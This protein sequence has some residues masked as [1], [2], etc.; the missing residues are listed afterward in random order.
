MTA[1]LSWFCAIVL[2]GASMPQS[3]VGATNEFFYR[4]DTHF[5][6]GNQ[7]YY[8]MGA[9]CFYLGYFAQ[10]TTIATNGMTWRDMSD[11]VMTRCEDLGLGVIRVWAFNEA[12]VQEFSAVHADWRMQTNP[13]VYR[14]QALVGLDYVMEAARQ[15]DLAVVLTLVNNWSAYGGMIWYVT[16]SPTASGAHDEFYTDGWCRQ[17][18]K[19][20][21]AVLANR[22]NT[23]NGRVYKEDPTLFGWQLANEPRSSSLSALTNW[24]CEMA[25]Y[26]QSVD[27][28]HMVSSGEEGW[29]PE[30]SLNSACSNID[31]A[32]MHCWPD[33]WWTAQSD[34]S[35]YSNAMNWV[36]DRLTTAAGEFCKPVVLSEYGRLH[37][38]WGGPPLE[39]TY[40]RH[41]YYRGWFDAIYTSAASDGPAAGLHFWMLEASDSGHD[42]QVGSVFPSEA[43]TIDLIRRQ[44]A[45]M[46]TLIA[47]TFVSAATT[48]TGMR[49]V[50]SGVV[51]QPDYGVDVSPDLSSW[52]RAI[53]VATNTWTDP[54]YPSTGKRFYRVVPEY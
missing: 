7:R 6:S 30:W 38:Q 43:S 8:Y 48:P 4:A 13:G 18:Y 27:T 1:P 12:N 40:G 31:Y 52:Q 11:E 14:E 9:N 10:D 50:W 28:N 33:S 49:L 34:E 24:V 44:A 3:T 15:R 32:V 53:T 20:H 22:T 23:F 25:A 41:S 17:W 26:I 2:A 37:S 36:A 42:D 29:E 21:F 45:E 54:A 46:N 5:M 16:N 39:A 35:M 51:G 19:D 47:P